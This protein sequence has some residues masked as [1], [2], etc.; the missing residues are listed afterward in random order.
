MYI[1]MTL[2]ATVEEFLEPDQLHVGWKEHS[3]NTTEDWSSNA[4]NEDFII[5]DNLSGIRNIITLHV[6]I[7]W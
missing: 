1:L 4:A 7:V 6:S 5:T 3:Q 2:V